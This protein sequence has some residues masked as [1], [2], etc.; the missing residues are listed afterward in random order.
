M[1]VTLIWL[2]SRNGSASHG[3][4]T[5]DA[6]GHECERSELLAAA[7]AAATTTYEITVRGAAGRRR[8]GA[9]NESENGR[10][11]EGG[12]CNARVV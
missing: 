4:S 10:Q 11:E 5:A 12:D 2:N 3:S 1:Q 7:A 9:T 6:D 8:G